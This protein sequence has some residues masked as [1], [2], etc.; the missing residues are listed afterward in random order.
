MCYVPEFV[1]TG[2]DG[3]GPSYSFICQSPAKSHYRAG[4]EP[5][6]CRHY[7]LCTLEQSNSHSRAQSAKDSPWDWLLGRKSHWS[8][9]IDA[10]TWRRYPRES[11]C[12]ASNI[13]FNLFFQT[14]SSYLVNGPF[15]S[16][17]EGSWGRR[18]A[19]TFP[20]FA[21]CSQGKPVGSYL[22]LRI[23]FYG[24]TL[25][26]SSVQKNPPRSKEKKEVWI[27][28]T[29]SWAT[30]LQSLSFSSSNSLVDWKGPFHHC[31]TTVRPK[32]S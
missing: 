30:A 18:V 28:D 11:E 15:S 31:F 7:Q 19:H 27:S 22:Q 10:Q 20:L 12:S 9:G 21:H 2:C 3:A 4:R 8:W 25:R 32:S 6:T 29:L 16:Y 17:L 5:Y 26:C 13:H 24:N 14:H 23:M 1:P